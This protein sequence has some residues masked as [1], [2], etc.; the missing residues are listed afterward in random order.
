MFWVIENKIC[1]F[2]PKFLRDQVALKSILA[3]FSRCIEIKKKKKMVWRF[4]YGSFFIFF[5]NFWPTKLKAF[6][7]ERN[8]GNGFEVTKSKKK[9]KKMV[10]EFEKWHFSIVCKFS[11]DGVKTVVW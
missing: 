1:Q 3:R 11:S 2:F 10:L 8:L 5:E 4:D 6:L 9:K 7:G